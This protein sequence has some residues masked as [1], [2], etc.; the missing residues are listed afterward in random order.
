MK[1]FFVLT[2]RQGFEDVTVLKFCNYL[3]SFSSEKLICCYCGLEIKH[4]TVVDLINQEFVCYLH[5]FCTNM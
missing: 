5:L 3:Y 1:N 2:L 4:S